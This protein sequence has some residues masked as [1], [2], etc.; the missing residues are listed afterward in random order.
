MKINDSGKIMNA[1]LTLLKTLTFL[2]FDSFTLDLLDSGCITDF[3]LGML[4]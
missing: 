4:I 2:K 1:N 3:Q